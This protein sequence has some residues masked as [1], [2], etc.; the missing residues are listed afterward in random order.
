MITREYA[1]IPTPVNCAVR[2][3]RSHILQGFGYFVETDVT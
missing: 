2:G 3:E 1:D